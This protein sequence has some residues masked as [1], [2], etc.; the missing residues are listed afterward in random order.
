MSAKSRLFCFY[1]ALIHRTLCNV[2]T[3]RIPP[4]DERDK[5]PKVK[6]VTPTSKLVYIFIYL[7]LTSDYRV[8]YTNFCFTKPKYAF[9]YYS[10]PGFSWHR[11][12]FHQKSGG[13]TA[14]AADPNWPDQ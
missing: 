3:W 11:V 12:N 2:I 6:N 10:C 8:D 7:F 4:K 14:R 9:L 1:R 5:T 13:D